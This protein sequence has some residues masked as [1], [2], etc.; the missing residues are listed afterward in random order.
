MSRYYDQPPDGNN[1]PKL[2]FGVK[3]I[4]HAVLVSFF[5][6]LEMVVQCRF[7]W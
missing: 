4:S 5:S 7:L 3:L 2:D 6:M 1:P